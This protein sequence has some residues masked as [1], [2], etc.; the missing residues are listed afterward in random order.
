MARHR[1]A[2]E[3][4]RALLKE[5]GWTQEACARAVNATGAE[6]GLRLAYDRTAVAHW[7]G[8][9]EPYEPVPLLMSEAFT[10]RL[11]RV[12][13][14]ETLGLT[15]G[16]D[17]ERKP[18]VR[19]AGAEAVLATAMLGEGDGQGGR[20]ARATPYRTMTRAPR[21]REPAPLPPAAEPA[22]PVRVGA[23]E[24][25]LLG[26]AVRHFALALGT[27]GGAHA[28]RALAVYL[29]ETVAA[30]LRAPCAEEVH[31]GLR[32]EAAHLVLVLG[33]MHTDM[34]EHGRAQGYFKASL[35]LAGESGDQDV[36]AIGLRALSAQALTL[37]H[38]AAALRCAVAAVDATSGRPSGAVRAYTLSQLAVVRAA[39][40]EERAALSALDQAERAREGDEGDGPFRSYPE[41][42]LAF[43]EAELHRL[44]GRPGLA[45]RALDRSARAR[46]PHDRRGLALTLARRAELL[47]SSGRIDEACVTWAAFTE[48]R[49]GLRSRTVVDASRGMR[50]ALAPYARRPGVRDLLRVPS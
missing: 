7:L 24:V 41:S 15:R 5:A 21:W 12:V 4:L 6:I 39:M 35:A 36:W 29:S 25:A 20:Q 31:R 3:R 22:G 48:A 19:D 17:T 27:H 37:G 49:A 14:P 43:Q 32:R 44:L 16:T 26:D 10:R 45:L 18:D 23:C 9:T 13:T 33:L 42:A 8:G 11:G 28:R 30:W 46:A 40:K 38:R 2:N 34:G 50:A 47:L 1:V